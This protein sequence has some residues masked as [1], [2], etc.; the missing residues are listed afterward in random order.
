MKRG[1]ELPTPPGEDESQ[2]AGDRQRTENAQHGSPTKRRQAQTTF[3]SLNEA[4]GRRVKL[5]RQTDSAR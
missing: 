4:D 3:I 5:E 2:H 1:A